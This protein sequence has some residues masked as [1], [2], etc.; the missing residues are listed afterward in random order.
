MLTNDPDKPKRKYETLILHSI[1]LLLFERPAFRRA[2]N[3][4][5]LF[6]PFREGCAER[7]LD[8]RHSSRLDP[9]GPCV[10]IR[11]DD[12][13][14]DSESLSTCIESKYGRGWLL[15]NGKTV[16]ME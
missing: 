6:M 13:D 2:A 15:V 8:N 1:Y 5:C 12:D 14:G 4:P 9:F 10:D 11:F 3:P 7:P 16:T